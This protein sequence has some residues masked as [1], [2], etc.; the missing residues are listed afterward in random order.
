MLFE[1]EF[2]N[3]EALRKKFKKKAK[4]AEKKLANSS[5]QWGSLE[6]L[7]LQLRAEMFDLAMRRAEEFAE[8]FG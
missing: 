3:A 5:A 1:E 8:N 6:N 2:N 7:E 4:K